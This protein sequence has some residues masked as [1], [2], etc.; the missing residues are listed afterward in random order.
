MLSLRLLLSV[1]A[2]LVLVPQSSAAD[3]LIDRLVS[4][5]ALAILGEQAA[6]PGFRFFVLSYEQPVN[7]LEPWKGMF[8]QRLTILHRS[9]ESPMVVNTAGYDIPLAPSRSEPT[10]SLRSAR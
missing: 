5:P 10:Q 8:A 3:E 4:V 9:L 7:H 6:P 1:L 2:A